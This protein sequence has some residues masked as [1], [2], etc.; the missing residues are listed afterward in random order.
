[1]TALAARITPPLLRGGAA[2]LLERNYLVYRRVWSVVISGFFEPLFYLFAIGVGIGEL[3]GDVVVP[4]GVTVEYAA[5]VAPGLLAA[6]AMNG[7]IFESTINIFFKLKYGKVF[8]GNLAAPNGAP[9]FA[10]G[11]VRWSLGGGGGCARGFVGVRTAMGLM[12]SGWGSLG[13]PGA[14]LVGL[15]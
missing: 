6:S 14:L 8:E 5:F 2:R 11:E 13:L 7:A 15:A 10:L 9:D 3:V 12:E 4:G 1:M